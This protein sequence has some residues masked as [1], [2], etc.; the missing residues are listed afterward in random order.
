MK[1]RMPRPLGFV[2]TL[3]AD[4][5]ALLWQ[6]ATAL[7]TDADTTYMHFYSQHMYKTYTCK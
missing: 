2:S 1:N 5:K 6:L 4:V 7:Q 3:R